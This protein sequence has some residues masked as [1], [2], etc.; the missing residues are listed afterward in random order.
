MQA[1]ELRELAEWVGDDDLSK[2]G[3]YEVADYLRACA[4]ALDAGPVAW[5]MIRKDDGFVVGLSTVE[6]PEHRLDA[7]AKGGCEAQPLYHVAMP[8]HPT[9]LRLPEPMGYAAGIEAV[10][11]MIEAKAQSFAGQH[12]SDDMGSL[13][14]GSGDH[15][16]AKS[17]YYNSLVELAEEVRAM[18]AAA[19]TLPVATPT[20]RLPEP[21]TDDALNKA[22]SR[23]RDDLLD[24]IYEHTTMS[25][26]ILPMVLALCRAIEAETLRRVKE[27]NK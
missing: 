14:F 2:R 8:A 15:A 27:A 4:D 21:M 16:E 24:H 1:S 26:G 19:P 9:T 11:A 13:S 3:R 23:L 20:L 10:A 6:Y 7:A 17:D 12:G 18:L 5:R 25:E 22:S